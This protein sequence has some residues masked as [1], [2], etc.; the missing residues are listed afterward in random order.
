MKNKGFSLIEVMAAVAIL[1][2]VTTPILK[3]F[4][5]AAKTNSKAQTRQDATSLSEDIMEKVKSTS[6]EDL[7]KESTGAIEGKIGERVIDPAKTEF[8][9]GDPATTSAVFLKKTPPYQINYRDITATLGK[10]YDATVN[11]STREYSVTPATPGG[12]VL[13][14][15]DANTFEIPDLKGVDSSKHLILSWEINGYD[16]SAVDRIVDENAIEMTERSTISSAASSSGNKTTRIEFSPVTEGS[17]DYVK[18]DCYVSYDIPGYANAVEFL[19]Y[20][21]TLPEPEAD[22]EGNIPAG[23]NI[24]L[25]YSTTRGAGSTECFKNEYVKINDSTTGYVHN[26]YMILQNGLTSFTD[27]SGSPSINIDM[28]ITENGSEVISS[29]APY[30]NNIIPLV[31]NGATLYTNGIKPDDED[32]TLTMEERMAERNMFDPKVKDRIYYVTVT[33]SK[34]GETCARLTST[35]DTGAEADN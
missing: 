33:V 2:I 19:A 30:T 20:T 1:A 12:D 6:I 3:S 18:I 7:Y 28:S 31:T 14:A 35:M 13:D 26:V 25:F 21:G 11:I 34:D 4:T 15:S 23:P 10:T 8:L 22:A 32:M 29:I 5:I 16:E 27:S 9:F 24:Y 17:S